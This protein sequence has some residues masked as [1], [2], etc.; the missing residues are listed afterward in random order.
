MTNENDSEPIVLPA[1]ELESAQEKE[2]PIQKYKVPYKRRWKKTGKDRRVIR[3]RAKNNLRQGRKLADFDWHLC[4]S[5]LELGSTLPNLSEKLRLAEATIIYHIRLMKDLS[6]AEY[7]ALKL[8]NLQVSLR[9]KV[10]DKALAG[11]NFCIGLATKH[12]LDWHDK[13]E[14]KVEKTVTEEKR[15]Y[16]V[17]WADEQS[18]RSAPE[19]PNPPAEENIK[20][21]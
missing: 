12:Y 1:V 14:I 10:I 5:L 15:V 6:F 11:D 18:D 17:G 2:I 9:K 20:L 4:D 16:R 21:Q 8:T 13:Q 3:P 19:T 7:R